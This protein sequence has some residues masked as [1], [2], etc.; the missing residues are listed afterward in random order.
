MQRMVVSPG[1]LRNGSG[2]IRL[3]LPQ[4]VSNRMQK[5]N[6]L[7]PSSDST[8]NGRVSYNCKHVGGYCTAVSVGSPSFNEELPED[9]LWSTRS[10]LSFMAEQPRQLKFIEWPSFTST[11]KTATL[12]LF[13]VAVFIVALSSVDSALCYILALILRKSP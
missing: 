1:L 10:L 11:L 9:P 8:L 6:V 7:G 13:L 2:L 5:S 12:S 4:I 3:A